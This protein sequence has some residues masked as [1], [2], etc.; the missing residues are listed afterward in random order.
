MGNR[1]VKYTDRFRLDSDMIQVDEEAKTLTLNKFMIQN[2]A[3][4]Q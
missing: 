1:I 3:D 4:E 2:L